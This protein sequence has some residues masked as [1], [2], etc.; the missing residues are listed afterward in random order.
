MNRFP[1]MLVVLACI[2]LATVACG[3]GGGKSPV[4]SNGGP[5]TVSGTVTDV[6]GNGVSGVTV[7]FT[8]TGQSYTKT[9]G[10][11]GSYSISFQDET[12][13]TVSAALGSFEA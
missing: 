2:M 8:A 9:T 10:S 11:N 5:Y 1:D 4:D 7:T 13:F 3:G 6:N 12:T